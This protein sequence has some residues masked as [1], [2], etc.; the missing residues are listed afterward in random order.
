VH[1]IVNA[2][3]LLPA[4]A[5][6][7]AT[8]GPARW[9]RPNL[10]AGC[11]PQLSW[12]NSSGRHRRSSLSVL[13][14]GVCWSVPAPAVRRVSGFVGPEG[15]QPP[16]CS[17]PDVSAPPRDGRSGRPASPDRR[18]SCLDVEPFSVPSAD[19]GLQ[20]SRRI[21]GPASLSPASPGDIVP[22]VSMMCWRRS[23]MLRCAGTP[24]EGRSSLDETWTWPQDGRRS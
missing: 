21:D 18:R 5:G 1:P 3:L 22:R 23:T 13:G 8:A 16:A 14:P 4:Y 17:P 12:A 2:V 6:P 19:T 20:N 7:G 9:R 24:H 15:A 10:G 11:S